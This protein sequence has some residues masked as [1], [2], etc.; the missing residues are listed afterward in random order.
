MSALSP[1]DT[2]IANALLAWLKLLSAAPS[3]ATFEHVATNCVPLCTVFANAAPQFFSN[4]EYFQST[5]TAQPNA[6]RHFRYNVRRLSRALATFYNLSINPPVPSSTS[7]ASVSSDNLSDDAFTPPPAQFPED[8]YQSTQLASYTAEHLIELAENTTINQSDILYTTLFLAECVL[9]AAT[10]IEEN[11]RFIRAVVMLPQ[12]M[13]HALAHSMGRISSAPDSAPSYPDTT[14]N[15]DNTSTRAPLRLSSMQNDENCPNVPTDNSHVHTQTREDRYSNSMSIPLV[16]FKAIAMERDSLRRKL[17]SVE[18][19]RMQLIDAETLWRKNADDVTDR[20]RS[21]EAQNKSL[22]QCLAEKTKALNDCTDSVRGLKSKNE[23]LELKC[24]KAD[25]VEEL[26]RNLKRASKELEEMASIRQH[27]KDLQAQ[28]SAFRDN[29]T[30]ISKHTEYLELQLSRGNERAG[31]LTT[32][33]DKLSSDLEEREARNEQLVE[34]NEGLRNKLELVTSQLERN[35]FQS[36]GSVSKTTGSTNSFPSAQIIPTPVGVV[37]APTQTEEDRKKPVKDQ[38]VPTNHT[39]QTD[40]QEVDATKSDQADAS[41]D[42]KAKQYVSDLLL[43]MLGVRVGWNDIVDCM[44]GVL[45]AMRDMNQSH[46]IEQHGASASLDNSEAVEA[47]ILDQSHNRARVSAD[48]IQRLR[49]SR[50]NVR[51][52]RTSRQSLHSEG[53]SRVAGSDSDALSHLS[54]VPE[55]RELDD[56]LKAK[57]SGDGDEFDY[58]ANTCN[59]MEIPLGATAGTEHLSEDYS[60]ESYTVTDS[61]DDDDNLDSVHS[62]EG[63]TEERKSSESRLGAPSGEE[64]STCGIADGRNANAS[65]MVHGSVGVEGARKQSMSL[66]VRGTVSR[67]TSHSETT[68]VIARQTR[69]D[70][71]ELQRRMDMM[72]VERKSCG[73]VTSLVHQLESAHAEL[74]QMQK[75]VTEAEAESANLRREMNLMLKELDTISVAMK[76]NEERGND[77]ISEKER[78]IAHMK[79]SSRLKEAEIQELRQQYDESRRLVEILREGEK[80]ALDKLEA[81]AVIERAHELEIAKLRAKLEATDSV[82]S[83]LNSVMQRTEGLTSE[84]SRQRNSQ[85]QTALEAARRD[86][87]LAEQARDEAK[88]VAQTHAH[89]LE[90]MKSNVAANAIMNQAVHLDERQPSVKKTPRF[91]EFWRRLLHRERP[92]GDINTTSIDHGLQLNP[93]GVAHRRL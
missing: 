3:H 74:E 90:N 65:F 68:S 58:A 44:H 4:R 52:L 15:R 42:E 64:R 12:S 43:D 87:E 69:K 30:R 47:R 32:L 51:K 85:M 50:E 26:E 19:E 53:N 91:Y 27:N 70:L 13:Q 36:N 88:R 83:R 62:M 16:D 22:E 67:S 10:S 92:H 6:T 21:F 45:D 84:V 46:D 81:N 28:L 35:L 61:C 49:G 57:N 76:S 72:R 60:Q 17:A 39:A 56:K 24:L 8:C 20:L 93:R 37:P 33:T 86:K 89:M 14:D 7:S 63:K 23:E 80:E 5:G 29:E 34:E 1:Q 71:R 55:F 66:A 38:A 82:A 75:K 11:D 18:A 9:C 77:I 40:V 79:E 2:E 59:V 25:S 41:F 31:G 78:L 48:D 54:F 73:S